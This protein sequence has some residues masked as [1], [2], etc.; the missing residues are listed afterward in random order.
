MFSA[1]LPMKTLLAT[2][3][4][5]GSRRRGRVRTMHNG[6]QFQSQIQSQHP[7]SGANL[8]EMEPSFPAHVGTA[9]M[10]GVSAAWRKLLQQAEMAAPHV[11]VASIE[12][13]SGVGK[14]TLARYLLGCSSLSSS[15]TFQRR[16]ARE[17]L[18]S[19]ADPA[20]MTGF[21]YL[22]RVDLLAPPGQGLLL[23]ELK[24]IQD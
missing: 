5:Y 4:R 11:Q 10:A 9:H 8:V 7:I 12:G 19:E 24:T 17:W 16:D 1:P 2:L 18:L 13:E 23:G 14:Q 15:S 22:D 6:G 21:T 3:D 20:G